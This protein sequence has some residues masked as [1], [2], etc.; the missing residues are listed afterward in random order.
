MDSI[1]SRRLKRVLILGTSWTQN[2]SLRTNRTYHH[3]SY[4]DKPPLISRSILPLWKTISLTYSV[5]VL[6]ASI[7]DSSLNYPYLEPITAFN[8]WNTTITTM[9]TR[10]LADETTVP[11]G[12]FHIGRLVYDK[13]HISRVHWQESIGEKFIIVSLINT[14]SLGR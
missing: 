6:I 7:N 9:S 3:H 11:I 5:D 4:G 12:T 1:P 13:T 8:L 14:I 2:C 10:D